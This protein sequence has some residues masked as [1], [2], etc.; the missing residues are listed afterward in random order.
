MRTK[1]SQTFF[2]FAA[3]SKTSIMAQNKNAIE[4]YKILDELLS[5]VYHHFTM[6]DLNNECNKR[7]PVNQQVSLRQ[8]QKDIKY[9]E[10]DGPFLMDIEHYKFADEDHQTDGRK[11]DGLRYRNSSIT[12]FKKKLSN[13]EKYLISEALNILGQFDGIPE[14][15]QLQALKSKLGIENHRKIVDFEKNP[16]DHTTL[17]GKLFMSI[18]NRQAVT[19]LY[20]TF[21]D[22]QTIKNVL[23]HPY[24]LKEH[25]NRW[26]LICGADDTGKI[27]NF[28]LDRLDDVIPMPAVQYKPQPSD[29][30]DRYD[31]IVGVTYF[32]ENEYE[33]VFFWVSD[34]IKD[35]IFT[36]PIHDMQTLCR[37]KMENDLRA[38][39]PQLKG[40]DFL[41][42]KC[43]K[44]MELIRE[45][46]SYG[47]DL[48]VLTESVRNDM[49]AIAQGM[50]ENYV[51]TEK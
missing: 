17:F 11:S 27:L 32:E 13:D 39:Y 9:L 1:N 48:V 5:N 26:Y 14:M 45:F 21:K 20:H 38:K 16:M 41:K 28:A 10:I 8:T 19:L 37:D 44:N 36:K 24:L 35:Y 18:S 4:R 22:K 40:G 51:K 31:E 3:E 12:I 43:R 25:H 47:N 50:V 46:C 23:V 29:F 7:L 33:N 2:I 49:K 30:V 42:I 6:V 15:D 34:N